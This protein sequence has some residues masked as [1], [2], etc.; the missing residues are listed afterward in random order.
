M[1]KQPD[2]DSQNDMSWVSGVE[3]TEG[4][5]LDSVTALKGER[6]EKGN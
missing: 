5:A 6:N 1:Q 4:N 2:H 3:E